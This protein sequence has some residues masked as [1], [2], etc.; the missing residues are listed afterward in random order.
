MYGP[1]ILDMPPALVHRTFVN[2][3]EVAVI[4]KSLSSR[5]VGVISTQCHWELQN[6]W[7]NMRERAV[8]EEIQ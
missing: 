6:I 7:S 3:S 4:L 2:A 8:A 1:V 5:S